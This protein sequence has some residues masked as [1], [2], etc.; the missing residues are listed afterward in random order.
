[1]IPWPLVFEALTPEP[2]GPVVVRSYVR[3]KPVN[4]KRERVHQALKAW[5]HSREAALIP[6]EGQTGGCSRQVV[7]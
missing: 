3:S 5:V 6:T 1:M 7:S 4:K 2:R